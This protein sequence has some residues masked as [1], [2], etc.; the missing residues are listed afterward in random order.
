MPTI[1]PT[2]DTPL[3]HSSFIVWHRAQ[4]Y[5][6]VG[7]YASASSRSWALLKAE[8]LVDRY[9]ESDPDSFRRHMVWC[10]DGAELWDFREMFFDW[11]DDEW[12]P[13]QRERYVLTE[14][15]LTGLNPTLGYR[16]RQEKQ[17]AEEAYLQLLEEEKATK[18]LVSSPSAS[19]IGSEAIEDSSSSSESDGEDEV[20]DEESSAEE[21]EEIRSY[22]NQVNAAKEGTM[23]GIW[24]I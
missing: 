3:L 16:I 11:M 9:D 10:I 13:Q 12:D 20:D 18:T 1:T 19:S 21:T 14:S 7:H 8:E 4:V 2:C 24:L 23:S 17:R 22:V 15:E 6:W 5:V